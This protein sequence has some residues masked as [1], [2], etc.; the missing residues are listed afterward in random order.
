[1]ALTYFREV[2]N[3]N[4]E[5]EAN[6]TQLTKKYSELEKSEHELR[7]QLTHFV[8]RSVNEQDKARI[9]ELEKQEM[10]LKLEASRLRELAEITLYQN[11]SIEFINSVAR[12]R[13]E[14]FK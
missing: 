3:R 13:M 5:L 11:S 6:F 2:E 1:M 9:K 14:S 7:D 4:I 12:T 8:P 10:L